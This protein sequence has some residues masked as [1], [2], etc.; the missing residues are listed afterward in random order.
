M[1]PSHAKQTAFHDC[2]V[3]AASRHWCLHQTEASGPL[4]I[5]L[6]SSSLHLQELGAIV[7]QVVS[8]LTD[9]NEPVR[10]ALLA[11]M[12]GQG[13]TSGA[14]AQLSITDLVIHLFVRLWS[15]LHDPA[16]VGQSDRPAAWLP[17]VATYMER[18]IHSSTSMVTAV[19]EAV[20][21]AVGAELSQLPADAM[22][23]LSN[24]G[25]QGSRRDEQLGS[26]ATVAAAGP[27]AEG[28][29]AQASSVTPD[30]P[31][32]LKVDASRVAHVE[33]AVQQL[34]PLLPRV[35]WA[36]VHA[37][38]PQGSSNLY[39]TIPFGQQ[40]V[41]DLQ[42]VLCG[43]PLFRMV[44]LLAL[45]GRLGPTQMEQLR[46]LLGGETD[47]GS[48]SPDT[49]GGSSPFNSGPWQEPSSL[50]APGPQRTEALQQLAQLV[51]LE[52]TPGNHWK[53]RCAAYVSQVHAIFRASGLPHLTDLHEKKDE[54]DEY[55]LQNTHYHLYK[56]WC[57][58]GVSGEV[59]AFLEWLQRGLLHIIT[60]SLQQQSDEEPL[61]GG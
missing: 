5:C 35:P 33:A 46:Q 44:C 56:Q 52:Q 21:S 14:Q 10:Q 53:E 40:T 32:P 54:E 29:A 30:H 22:V 27:D 15:L 39:P 47:A 16:V 42:Q 26:G 12:A 1:Q 57:F 19:D 31:P 11:V 3:D 13:G 49:S 45:C 43:A 28:A 55:F 36:Q 23:S 51:L 50:A 58:F 25:C 59:Q 20:A 2:A 7:E 17:K 6:R 4:T 37:R 61:D 9:T 41:Y 18:S 60:T 38:L 24:Q 48:S 8:P 34:A